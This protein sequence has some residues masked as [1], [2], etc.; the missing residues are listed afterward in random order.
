MRRCVLEYSQLNANAAKGCRGGC[1]NRLKFVG[2]L[3]QTPRRF[4]ERSRGDASDIDGQARR[5]VSGSE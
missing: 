2:R 5:P 3:C 1:V 4:K